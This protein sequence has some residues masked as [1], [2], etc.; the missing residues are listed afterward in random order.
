MRSVSVGVEHMKKALRCVVI[1]GALSV[2]SLAFAASGI[3]TS[4]GSTNLPFNIQGVQVMNLSTTGLSLAN[5]GISI[6]RGEIQIGMDTTSCDISHA[7]TL[8]WNGGATPKVFEGCDGTNWVPFSAS[9]SSATSACTNASTGT[10]RWNAQTSAFEGCNGTA[11]VSVAGDSSGTGAWCGVS[12]AY[13]HINCQGMDP[14]S[15]CPT[16]YNQ[17]NV[18][19]TVYAPNNGSGSFLTCTKS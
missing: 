3:D 5:T 6:P 19:F 1:L 18:G 8:R 2:P 4:A 11:W 15:G 9:T 12:S 10:T 16:G 7:G 14:A 17:T 13:T